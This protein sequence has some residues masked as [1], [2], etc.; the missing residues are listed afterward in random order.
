[1]AGRH[2]NKGVL[3]VVL[4]VE[5]MPYLPDGTP[6]DMVLNPLGVPSRMNV[7]QVL[8]THLGWV[9]YKMGAK[10]RNLLDTIC[11]SKVRLTDKVYKDTSFGEEH[12]N[13]VGEIKST[14][15][16]AFKEKDKAAFIESLNDKEVLQLAQK[17]MT[18]VHVASPVFEGVTEA[19]MLEL[20]EAAGLEGTLDC[21]QTDLFDGKSGQK[22]SEKV[23]VGVMY[24][25][26]LHHLSLIH[27]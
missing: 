8:E 15:S 4:P 23:T 14:F 17:S 7:G 16:R 6:V 19:E 21:T 13:V 18:G 12:S 20:A 11:D 3:S 5:D 25:L 9:S 27:I 10:F 1:M 2:G 22:F 26:K 24:M